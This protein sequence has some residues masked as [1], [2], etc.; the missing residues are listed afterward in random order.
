MSTKTNGDGDVES[1]APA[2]APP[3]APAPAPAPTIFL[4][5]ICSL[6]LSS[7]LAD[8]ESRQE[9]PS[10]RHEDRHRRPKS[11]CQRREQK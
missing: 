9:A 10:S 1:P 5:L 6:P 4:P 11:E 3:P 2:P 7:L 8:L